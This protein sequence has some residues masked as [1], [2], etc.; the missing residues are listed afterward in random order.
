MARYWANSSPAHDP[1]LPACS[2]ET[3]S[4]MSVEFIALLL[5]PKV[6]LSVSLSRFTDVVPQPDDWLL[7]AVVFKAEYAHAGGTAEENPSVGRRQP[8]PASRNHAD[9]VAAGK[10][11]NVAFHAA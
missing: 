1:D 10:R 9:D 6:W 4:N 3:A 7:P 8:V 11:Q 5:C 2:G